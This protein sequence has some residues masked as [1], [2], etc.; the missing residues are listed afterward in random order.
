MKLLATFIHETLEPD[1]SGH[2]AL[3]AFMDEYVTISHP[4][5]TNKR[6]RFWFFKD[7]SNPDDKGCFVAVE[8][9]QSGTEIHVAS[10]EIRPSNDCSKQ[11]LSGY[12][13]KKLV[14]LADK[15]K[16]ILSLEAKPFGNKG[17][18]QTNLKK[19][20]HRLGFKTDTHRGRNFMRRK[21]K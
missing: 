13:F 5:L 7:K 16:V 2:A 17:M 9:Y 21:P 6:E 3:G 19:W 8:L 20:Y 15:H 1:T 12:V 4:G 11:G 14:A 18:T 10:I